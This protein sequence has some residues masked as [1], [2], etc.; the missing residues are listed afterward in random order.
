MLL[1]SDPVKTRLHLFKYG[2]TKSPSS[3]L[4]TSG[5]LAESI[6]TSTFSDGVPDSSANILLMA[7]FTIYQFTN[8]RNE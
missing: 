8:D 7:A 5:A 2:P 4:K 6:N 3:D 1:L